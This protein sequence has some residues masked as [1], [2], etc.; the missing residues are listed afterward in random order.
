M[1][2]TLGLI[3]YLV[4]AVFDLT[5]PFIKDIIPFVIVSIT[6]LLVYSGISY[7]VYSMDIYKGR[8]KLIVTACAWM[9]IHSIIPINELFY[10]DHILDIFIITIQILDIYVFMKFL[11]ET[12]PKVVKT[13]RENYL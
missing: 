9:F 12:E 8:I 10:H 11:L 4:Y 7:L 5:L 2:I 6:G 3:S 13:N 1:V